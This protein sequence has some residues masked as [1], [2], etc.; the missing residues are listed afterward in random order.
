MT[1]G[2]GAG[3]RSMTRQTLGV[4]LRFQA[5]LR[6]VVALVAFAALLVGGG[7]TIV[8][9]MQEVARLR[10]MD[11]VAAYYQTRMAETLQGQ[12]DAAVRLKSRLDYGR[13]L[14][15]AGKDWSRFRGYITQLNLLDAYSQIM[16]TDSEDQTLFTSGEPVLKKAAYREGQ[17]AQWHYI[18]GEDLLHRVFFLPMVLEGGRS[19]HLVLIQPISHGI[20]YGI[21]Y[22]GTDV[23]L[24]RLGKVLASSLGQAGTDFR[25]GEDGLV[26]V[27]E[28]QAMQRTLTVFSMGDEFRLVVHRR[29]EPLFSTAQLVALG[30]T[31]FLLLGAALWLSLW[32]WLIRVGRRLSALKRGT[33][34]YAQ[35]PQALDKLY[36]E[37]DHANAR[38]GDDIGQVALSLRKLI[39]TLAVREHERED[40]LAAQAE[41]R[42]K[43]EFLAN[44]SHEIRT[45]LNVIIGLGHLLRR[46]LD[47]PLQQER[48]DQLCASAEHLLAI[49]NDV[50]DLSKIEAQRLTLD[51][52]DFRLDAVV[53]KVVRMIE[54]SA[55][56]KGLTLTTDIAPHLRTLRLHGDP[57]RLAQ[58]LINLCGNAVKFTDHGAVRL[59]IGCLAEDAASVALRFT[60]EDTGI[61]IAP[62]DQARLFQPFTQ[63]DNSFTR[64]HGGTGLGLAISQRL[65]VLMGGTIW[66]D[67][68]PGTGSVFSFEL[69]LPRAIASV[70]EVAAAALAT[71]F[72]GRRVLFAEDHPLSQDILFEMLVDLGCEVDVAS[73]GAEAVA[74]AQARSYDIILMDMQMPKMDGRAA[75]RAIRV[76]P[77]HRETPIIGL[78]ANAFAEDRQRCLDAGMNGHIAKPVTPA[79]LAACLGQWL[80]DLAVPADETPLCD[81]ELSRALAEIPGLD[82]GQAMRRSSEKLADYCALLDRFVKDHGQDMVRLREHLAAG[83]HDAARVVAHKLIGIA[84][85][86]GVRRVASLANEIEQRL[87]AGADEI[88]IMSLAA[89][90]EAELASLVEAT[91]ALF[92]S[93]AT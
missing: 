86:I 20:L 63:V 11:G 43:S 47:D 45:P 37:L 16:I 4:S 19:G 81:N 28:Y 55:H 92:E 89:E 73:D 59:G 42:A 71:D 8:T 83:G 40:K 51:H 50:L 54:G 25:S 57:L 69:A 18:V 12:D 93:A 33:D 31:S 78:T 85:L 21:T 87:R 6:L 90:C 10:E 88:G 15:D 60:V 46:D 80:P 17:M 23:Y 49:I 35:A 64:E 74:C 38:T 75:A 29:V 79:T 48:L 7:I 62:A 61:G 65:V 58:V 84:G 68:N 24:L 1:T 76:L 53:D 44:M 41:N 34:S 5:V 67:S 82:I 32:G 36:A 39:E 22:P 30:L 66:V 27:G 56:E 91:R 52:C 70:T 2:P 77:G 9:H 13:I 14:T 3:N 72:G 26:Q